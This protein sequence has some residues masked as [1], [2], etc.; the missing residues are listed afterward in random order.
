M[1]SIEQLRVS[2]K[3]YADRIM[4]QTTDLR[5][6]VT[7]YK[8]ND[9]SMAMFRITA[10]NNIQEFIIRKVTGLKQTKKLEK[11]LDYWAKDGPGGIGENIIALFKAMEEM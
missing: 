4:A 8:K 5:K 7:L 10:M 3:Y 1:K 6:T 11:Y 2:E 9:P